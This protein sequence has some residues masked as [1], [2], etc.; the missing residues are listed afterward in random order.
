[1]SMKR[2]HVAG[3]SL[4]LALF[5]FALLLASA[6]AGAA[7]PQPGK[8]KQTAK[9]VQALALDWPR[10]AY[11]RSDRRVGVWNLS[12]GAT[13]DIKGNYPSN[14]R[15]FG[16]GSGEVA[17]AGKRVA[18]I[19][20]F[21]IGN[22]LQTQERL[23]T[24]PL[25]GTARQLGKLT[26]H[27]T[28]P[29]LCEQSDPGFSWG[30]WIAG[31]VGSGK[32]LAVSTW[33]ATDSV[34]GDERLSLVTPTGLRT[35]VTG[36]GAAVA[37]SA[38]SGH[39][40]VLRATSAWPPIGEVG[41]GT[42]TPTV[43]IYSGDGTLLGEIAL[44]S[45]TISCGVKPRI[46]IALSGNELVVLTRPS[47]ASQT[48]ATF[49][50]YDWTTGTLV[51]TWAQQ[52]GGCDTFSAAGRLVAYP[53]GC[54]IGGTQRLHL[55]DLKTGKDVVIAHAPGNGGYITA[56]GSHGLVYSTNPYA[57][58]GAHGKLVFVPTAK[59]LAALSK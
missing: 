9:P 37:Q 18:L 21:V 38:D 2:P 20:R 17:I 46:E 28:D 29:Q 27:S 3:L 39:V 24:A 51:H 54:N 11:M 41:P 26:N 40:A 15:K 22:D 13:S 19:T 7:K 10:V 34:A 36:P 31:V 32:V 14:G 50:L 45:S 8:V 1:M 35:I 30:N 12:T 23:Y 56:M 47:S 57:P 59:L 33:K 43:G 44:P 58:T 4:A 25:K 5:V 42:S 6:Q 55:L 48:Q 49:T 52:R 16:H 53:S